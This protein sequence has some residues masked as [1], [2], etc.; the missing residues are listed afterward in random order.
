MPWRLAV[1]LAALV[2]EA[3]AELVADHRTDGAVVDGI[4]GLH[5]EERWLQDG[6]GEH[7]FIHRRVVVG[8]D[9]L[10]RHQPFVTIDGLAELVDFTLVFDAA[11][12][13]H[14]AKQIRCIH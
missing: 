8:I 5:V 4:I 12:T 6:G 3:V 7:H 14:V 11:R 10:R 1:E 2:I 13:H 9:G